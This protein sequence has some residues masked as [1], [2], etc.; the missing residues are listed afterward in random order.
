M[1]RVHCPDPTCLRRQDKKSERFRFTFIS[2]HGFGRCEC[3]QEYL[4]FFQSS[5]AVVVGLTPEQ[6]AGHQRNA[7]AMLASIPDPYAGLE[8]AVVEALKTRHDELA[9]LNAESIGLRMS[10]R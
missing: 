10:V 2:G 3:G 8:P 9:R 6:A 7:E 4:A 5:L 1:N